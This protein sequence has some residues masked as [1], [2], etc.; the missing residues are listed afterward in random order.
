ME[1][2][3]I[4]LAHP[5]DATP[6]GDRASASSA[7]W[8]PDGHTPSAVDVLNLL[9]RY[10]T[11]ETAMRART[12]S[13]MHMNETDLLALRHL[14]RAQQ[15]GDLVR[16]RDLSTLLD[17]SSASVTALVDR[18]EQSGHV[19]RRPHPSDRRSVV[20]VPTADT[21][22]EVRHT[23]GD[24]HQRMIAVVDGMTGEQLV[25]VG[26]FLAGMVEAVEESSTPPTRSA[27]TR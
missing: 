13:S 20:V 12:R 5:A 27:Q 8:Y 4:A 25:A 19:E 7:Y 16:Q 26:T 10:R 21:D 6:G 3:R 24:M 18:L 22:R 14:L 17:I 11:A 1:H 23:L 2:S 9:R 15:R